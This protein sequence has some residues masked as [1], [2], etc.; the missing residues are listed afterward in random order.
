MAA[1]PAETAGSTSCSPA[2]PIRRRR[3][4]SRPGDA[5]SAHRYRAI[6]HHPA[7]A[8]PG[9]AGPHPLRARAQRRSSG[10]QPYTLLWREQVLNSDS[11]QGVNAGTLEPDQTVKSDNLQVVNSEAEQVVN[12]DEKQ[13]VKSD[14]QTDL[15]E[16]TTEEQKESPS[17]SEPRLPTI[18][19]MT[20]ALVSRARRLRATP[21]P[22]NGLDHSIGKTKSEPGKA[23]LAEKPSQSGMSH[24]R[25][26]AAQRQNREQGSHHRVQRALRRHAGLRHGELARRMRASDPVTVPDRE[27]TADAALSAPGTETF[28]W[29]ITDTHLPEIIEGLYDGQRSGSDNRGTRRTPCPRSRR[30]APLPLISSMAGCWQSPRS[31]GCSSIRPPTRRC[32]RGLRR[33]SCSRATSPTAFG[34]LWVLARAQP[35]LANVARTSRS[36]RSR[37]RRAAACRLRRWRISRS[38]KTS[39][40]I[41]L[42]RY[43]RPDHA[44]GVP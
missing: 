40:S 26:R 34:E 1:C 27:N 30:A 20:G 14:N 3:S 10:Q 36:Y 41:R 2:S 43:A 15:R 22:T 19:V 9:A 29:C 24:R 21:T 11:L 5:E 39:Q 32:A 38:G 35:L 18:R 4:A 28:D 42:R 31:A 44:R 25:D 17:Y 37:A 12:S 16:Q 7:S 8:A 13:T 23:A 6:E 33:P